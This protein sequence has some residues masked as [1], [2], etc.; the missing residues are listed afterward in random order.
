MGFF[1]KAERRKAKL[2]LGISGS[3]GSGKTYS[4]LLIAY[5]ITQDWAKIALIDTERGSGELYAGLGGYC[6]GQI[7]SP[8]TPQKYINAIK[9][10]EE[11]GFEVVIID[12]LSHAWS[13]EGGLL[14][15]QDAATK[16][17]KTGNSYMAWRQI[18]PLHNKLIDTILQ[19]KSHIIVTTRAKTEY[20]LSDDN[21][22]K[23]PK[24]I[25]LA[26]IFRDGLEFEMTT[27]FEISQEHIIT[28][29]KDRTGLFD[30]TNFKAT[31][32]TGE[33]LSDW[34]NSGKE[35][36]T[37]PK[38]EKNPEQKPKKDDIG[39]YRSQLAELVK[40]SKGKITF[41]MVK[42]TM[43]R[44]FAIKK[45]NDLNE[46]QFIALLEELTNEANS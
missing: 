5:G 6:V 20:A 38:P 40:N 25:G 32:E 43:E 34:L 19:S 45:A 17:S 41:D 24:K 14:D 18:T 7:D 10:A 27:F 44:K 22:K 3:S 15:M 37:P 30:N 26:P 11:A 29:T 9:E 1:E 39:D 35:V 33:L 23:V 42:E 2:R 12:S 8:F 28:A 4:S 31:K 16:A 13:G 21:G 36:V 46:D